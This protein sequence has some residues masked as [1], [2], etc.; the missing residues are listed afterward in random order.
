[1]FRTLYYCLFTPQYFHH[2]D[3]VRLWAE[4]CLARVMKKFL[5]FAEHSHSQRLLTLETLETL[6]LKATAR[7]DEA[8][9]SR[10][11]LHA[12][13]ARFRQDRVL[14]WMLMLG[15]VAL[16]VYGVAVLVDVRGIALGIL[17]VVTAAVVTCTA[18][19]G[20]DRILA[21]AAP[22]RDP[23]LSLGAWSRWIQAGA[24]LVM[25]LPAVAIAISR[26]QDMES[27]AQ[28]SPVGIVVMAGLVLLS[29]CMPFGAAYCDREMHRLRGPLVAASEASRLARGIVVQESTLKQILTSMEARWQQEV[30]GAWE[31]IHRFKV[32]KEMRDRRRGANC[33]TAGGPHPTREDFTSTALQRLRETTSWA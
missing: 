15:E 4:R 16:A 23:V 24:G 18:L 13:R 1:M 17:C 25:I 6:K 32:C 8:F 30:N 19:L 22:P 10:A 27:L 9:T 11:Q 26:A 33:A 7:R 29:F 31:A 5:P 28:A 14:F 20:A 12:F 21:A 3:G 2:D